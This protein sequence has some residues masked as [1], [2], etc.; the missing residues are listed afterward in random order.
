M[1][2]YSNKRKEQAMKYGLLYKTKQRCY[3]LT[4]LGKYAV[5]YYNRHIK[6]DTI[7]PPTVKGILDL[8]RVCFTANFDDSRNL[9]D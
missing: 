7:I 8:P 4:L 5:N 6:N 9:Y 2:R 1:K 3:K